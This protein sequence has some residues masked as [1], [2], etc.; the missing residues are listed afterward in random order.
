M[1]NYNFNKDIEIGEEGEMI[2]A[3]DLISVGD[4]LPI[5]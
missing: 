4:K 5:G 2:V 3:A 1:A